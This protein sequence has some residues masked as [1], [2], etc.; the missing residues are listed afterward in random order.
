M[1]FS[2]ALF[3]GCGG[4]H[5][6]A[7]PAGPSQPSALGASSL[8][9]LSQSPASFDPGPMPQTERQPSSAMV[10]ISASVTPAAIGPS[11][12]KRVPGAATRLAVAPDGSLW[13]LSTVPAGVNKYLWHYAHGAWTNVPGLAAS[14]AVGPDGTLYAVNGS[15]GGTYAYN[16]SCWKS[17]GGGARWV[18]TGADGAVYVLSNARIVNGD[19]AIW[20]YASGSWT[21]QPGAGA[22]LAGSFDPKSYSIDYLGT[23][24]PN[25]YFVITAAGAISYYSPGFGYV[26]FPEAA[27]AIAPFVG[28]VVDLKYPP[29]PSGESLSAFF[30]DDLGLYAQPIGWQEETGTGVSL[31]AGPSADGPWTQLYVANAANAIWTEPYDLTRQY[32]ISARATSIASGPDGALWF[33]ENGAGK[34][35]RIAVNGTVTAEYPIPTASSG[36]YGIAAGPDG[37]LWFT[38]NG[39]NKIGRI[40]T[41]GAFT[42]YPIPAAAS[43]PL[44]IAAGPDGALWFTENGGNKIGRI[45]T[46][47]IVSEYPIP[48]ASSAPRGIAAGGDGALWFVE[49]AGDNIG[50]I[51]TAGAVTAEYPIPTKGSYPEAI[52]AGPDGALWFTE[53]FGNKIGRITTAGNTSEFGALY[54]SGIAAGPDGAMWFTTNYMH[55]C[56]VGRITTGGNSSYYW[57]AAANKGGGIT[58]GPDG[59]IWFTDQANAEAEPMIARVTLH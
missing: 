50:R 5:S 6:A 44:Y 58:A 12:W 23:L 8:Y 37:A 38:E 27:S 49:S 17:L 11:T 9:P 10:D 53:N 29:S 26:P 40:T 24:A 33:T 31:A 18:T 36:P 7:L 39:S 30:Y 42:E 25:G 35:G 21:Q 45:T 3:A 16:G 48:T 22:Q 55:T 19:S 34:I 32:P 1:A 28:G 2:A 51:T 56:Q 59:A 52:V 54:P 43:G 20:K 47:G 15:T 13:A 14:I 57:V 46:S 4:G 41:G